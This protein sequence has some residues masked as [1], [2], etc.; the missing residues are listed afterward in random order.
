MSKRTGAA[1]YRTNGN[2][3]QSESDTNDAGELAATIESPETYPRHFSPGQRAAAL[4]F[5]D[6][7]VPQASTR[8]PG[9]PAQEFADTIG[10]KS[11]RPSGRGDS[12]SLVKHSKL[13]EISEDLKDIKEI[14]DAISPLGASVISNIKSFVACVAQSRGNGKAE[15]Q[16]H[17]LEIFGSASALPG[18][19]VAKIAAAAQKELEKQQA[20]IDKLT[21]FD[22]NGNDKR[23]M[24]Y[25]DR[26]TGEKLEDF[27]RREYAQSGLIARGITRPDISNYDSPLGNAI[28]NHMNY[29]DLPE[30]VTIPRSRS[31]KNRR[32]REAVPRRTLN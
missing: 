21:T 7:H 32:E 24:K 20:L 2:A 1:R 25:L 11:L 31:R 23:P 8:P 6:D 4:E 9:L 3:A 17:L 27:L 16:D 10:A 30:E 22:A 19:C 13:K 14:V 18:Q 28:S 29:A 5:C 12:K 26:P 15:S